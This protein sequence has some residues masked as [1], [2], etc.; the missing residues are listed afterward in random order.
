MQRGQR[1]AGSF[2]KLLEMTRP[3]SVIVKKRHTLCKIV[4]V[5]YARKIIHETHTQRFSPKPCVCLGTLGLLRNKRFKF[6]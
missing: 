4:L 3:D 5:E 6:M 1:F 2:Q